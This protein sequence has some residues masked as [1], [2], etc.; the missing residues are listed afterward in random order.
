MRELHDGMDLLP[1]EREEGSFV[2]CSIGRWRKFCE[3][4]VK[5][6]DAQAKDR[7]A[8]GDGPLRFVLGTE[9]QQFSEVLDK[10]HDWLFDQY[11]GADKLKDHLVFAH[12]DVSASSNICYSDANI[13]RHNTETFCA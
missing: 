3:P 7:H 13:I 4:I 12:N 1:I 11:G 10:Y 5:W 2:W 9:W 6:L 8:G